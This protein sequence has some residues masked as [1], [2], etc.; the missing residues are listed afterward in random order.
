MSRFHDRSLIEDLEP[1][2]YELLPSLARVE[3]DRRDFLRSVGGGLVVLCLL[4]GSSAQESGRGRRSGQAEEPREVGAWIR[5]AED[6]TISA[7]TGKVEVGQNART[8]LS[9]AVADELRVPIGSVVIVMG[10]TDRVPYDR[11]TFG[12]RTTPTMAPQLR[13]AAASARATLVGLAADR[14]GVDRAEVGVADGRVSHPPSGRSLGFGEL[15]EGR[16]LVDA[17]EEEDEPTPPERWQVAGKDAGK[18][19]GRDFVTGRH[20]YA[21]DISRPGMLRGK[22]LRP[23]HYGA[24]LEGIDASNAEAIDGVT[25]VRDG[26][27]IGVA[28][29]DEATAELALSALRPVWSEPE[30]GRPSDSSVYDYFKQN[31]GDI[32]RRDE[33]EGGGAGAIDQALGRSDAVVESR[34]RIAYIAHAPLEPRAA[35]AE[36]DG[37]RLTVWTGTQRP[38]GVREELIDAFGL[39]EESVRVVVPDTGSGYGGKHTGEAAIEAARLARAS[40]RPVK[41]TWTRP[42]EFTW[43]Y[44]R[45]A[46]VIDARVAC[47]DDGTLTAWQFHNSNSGASGIEPPYAIEARD[48]GFVR[49]DSPLRQGSYRALAATAN[50]FARE[51]LIDDLAALIGMDPLAFRLKNL[52]VDRVRDVLEAAADR[53]GWG[54]AEPG[55]GRGFGLACGMEKGGYVA[56]CAEVAVDEESGRVDVVRAVTAFECGAIVNPL[57]LHNQVEGAVVQGLGGALFERIRFEGGTILTDR[58]SRY[59]L[60]RFTD[61]PSIEIVLLD[62]PDLPSSGAGETPIVAIAP[63]IGNAIRAATGVRIRSLPLV[64]EGFRGEG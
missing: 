35:V 18:V 52:N 3:L 7:F 1:E 11:G 26:D 24:T 9:Q 62:R 23:P 57:H 28:A 22:V 14:W 60:P 44:F 34:Y 4:R 49:V 32:Q 25:V 48:L 27:F 10:D 20:E 39:S 37:D 16:R 51:S 36:W 12:S 40:G 17:I 58:F 21:S 50:H 5:I 53:F 59:R 61:L 45:P 30:E 43:A 2:R 63:A 6:G 46:G 56:S 38:F 55:P 64:P 15:T 19:D 31:P 33:P 54:S 8:S 41:L 42:E 13:R 47:R 29:P